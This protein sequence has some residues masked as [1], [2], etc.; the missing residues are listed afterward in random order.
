MLVPE[1]DHGT[2]YTFLYMQWTS[3]LFVT[4]PGFYKRL[5]TTDVIQASCS[6][7]FVAVTF[8]AE[9]TCSTKIFLQQWPCVRGH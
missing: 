4:A 1:G 6:K 8:A 7:L 9:V 5:T 3:K 2:N